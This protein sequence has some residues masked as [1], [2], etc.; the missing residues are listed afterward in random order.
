LM[1]TRRDGM[2]RVYDLQERVLPEWDDS[3]AL[4]R[5]AAFRELTLKAV[6]ALGTAFPRCIRW[7]YHEAFRHTPIARMLPSL[8]ASL[9]EEGEVLPV[10]V[11][12]LRGTAYV[13]REYQELMERAS[14]GDLQSNVTT[15]LSPF[16]PVV[17]DRARTSDLFG[18]DYRIEVYTPAPR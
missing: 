12:G 18:F 4:S 15:L 10:S 5:E 1:I 7:F 8:F 11:E 2:Q 6:R 9:V 14:A 13:H 3:R 17:R 16:D